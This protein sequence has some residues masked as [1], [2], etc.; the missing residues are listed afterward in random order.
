MSELPTNAVATQY[1]GYYITPEGDVWS[2][3]VNRK[4]KQQRHP[5]GYMQVTLR[6]GTFR[7]HRLLAQAFI[8]NPDGLP[9]VCHLDDVK[10]NNALSNLAWGTQQENVKQAI[11][12]GVFSFDGLVS[13]RAAAKAR[14]RRYAERAKE[15]IEHGYTLKEI[16]PHFGRTP[17]A[18]CYAVNKL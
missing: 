6:D 2:T 11:G 3:H 7:V 17:S 1:A 18:I 9:Y 15:M 5:R 12:N 14:S 16:A 13:G 10:D 4:L 8:P